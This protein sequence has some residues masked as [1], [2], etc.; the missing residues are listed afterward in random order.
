MGGESEQRCG[1]DGPGGAALKDIGDQLQPRSE[2]EGPYEEVFSFEFGVFLLLSLQQ[3]RYSKID[4]KRPKR[5]I[6]ED[7]IMS[8]VVETVKASNH[9]PKVRQAIYRLF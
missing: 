3:P 6:P 1:E 8:D 4:D 5:H 7:S 9:H 2:D